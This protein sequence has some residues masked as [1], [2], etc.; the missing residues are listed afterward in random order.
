MRDLD[1]RRELHRELAS[2]HHPNDT[3]IVD[4]LG[5]CQGIQRVDVAVIN[6]EL[7]GYEIKAARDTLERLPRQR[8]AYGKVFNRVYLVAA[9][10][11]LQAVEKGALLPGWWGLLLADPTA[12]GNLALRGIRPAQTNPHVDALALTQLLWREEALAILEERD[13]ASPAL[14]RGSRRH[15]WQRIADCLNG[16]EIARL[17]RETLKS[18][19]NWRG[20][21]AGRASGDGMS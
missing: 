1:V 16:A 8:D 15:M 4:E 13:L 5:V 6:G 9:E 21:H 14:R 12:E 20:R 18:R 11:H 19:P 7:V 17:V 10:T 3:L 2:H